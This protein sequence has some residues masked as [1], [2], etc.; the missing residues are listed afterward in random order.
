[1]SS[2]LQNKANRANAKRSS[3]PKTVLGKA[4]SSRNARRHGLSSSSV[5]DASGVGALAAPLVREI[6]VGAAQIDLNEVVRAKMELNRI[7]EVRREM[8]AAL[9]EFPDAKKAKRLQ[10]LQRYQKQ[11][12]ARQKRA[13]GLTDRIP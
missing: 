5:D 2:N 1:M 10:N 11:A 6:A 13:L 12:F 4:K 9:L 7:R 8:I 3:G